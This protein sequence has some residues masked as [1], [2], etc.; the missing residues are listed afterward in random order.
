MPLYADTTAL[1]RKWGVFL[2]GLVELALGRAE[3]E[4]DPWT[5]LERARELLICEDVT[6]EARQLAQDCA[7]A[8]LAAG[9]EQSWVEADYDNI[10]ELLNGELGPAP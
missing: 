10:D 7:Q 1:G 5:R 9:V 4:Q 3:P 8:M 6:E 2:Q